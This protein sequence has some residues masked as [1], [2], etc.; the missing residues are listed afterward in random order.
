MITR[1]FIAGMIL[2]SS[3]ATALLLGLFVAIHL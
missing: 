3:V 1:A 2:G